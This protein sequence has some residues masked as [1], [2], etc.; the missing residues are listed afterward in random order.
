MTGGRS[1][2]I[3]VVATIGAVV[4]G[5]GGGRSATGTGAPTLATW[6]LASSTTTSTTAT[7]LQAG[8]SDPPGRN[9][10]SIDVN[11]VRRSAVV[12]VPVDT[13]HPVPVV[14]VFHGHGGSGAKIARRFDI[15]G[16]WRD[17]VVVYPDGLVGHQGLTDPQGLEP[18]WQTRLGERGDRDLAF[19]DA[20][21]S[22]LY[23]KLPVDRDRVF[24][25]GHSNG[26][27]FVSLLLNQRGDG[28]A[29]TANL[30][31]QPS[32]RLLHS[33]PVRSMFMAMGKRDPIVP[34]AD[35]AKSIPLAERKLGVDRSTATVNGYLRSERGH[36]NVELATYVYPGGHDPPPEVPGLVVAF[37]QRHTRSAG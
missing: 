4:T 5:C 26:S 25:I 11:G 36:G 21:R 9:M 17:A 35:Q 10:V 29:A 15:E 18:G 14:F 12:V 7:V 1:V 3:G 30:S 32:A 20:V 22:A 28:I 31:S 19:Y 8:R 34:Y 24:L 13:S 6:A 16:L 33:D 27:A 37:F 23:A 2:L